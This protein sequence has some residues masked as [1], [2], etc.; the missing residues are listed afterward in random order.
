[1]GDGLR[2]HECRKYECECYSNREIRLLACI[3]DFCIELCEEREWRGFTVNF[4][5]MLY[6]ELSR[7]NIECSSHDLKCAQQYLRKIDEI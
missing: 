1:M 7:F 6:N 5:D 3:V 4:Q 2:C